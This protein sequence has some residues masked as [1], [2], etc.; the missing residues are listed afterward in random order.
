MVRHGL[1]C[2][3]SSPRYRRL[4][5]GDTDSWFVCLAAVTL[6]PKVEHNLAFIRHGTDTRAFR[7]Q[8]PPWPEAHEAAIIGRALAE[9]LGVP[10]H[11]TSPDRPGIDLPG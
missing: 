8:A 4:W 2:A 6:E 10:F 7:G 5:D 11:F 3:S 9:R 1:S